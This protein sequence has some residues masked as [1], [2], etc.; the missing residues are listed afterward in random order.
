MQLNK[1]MELKSM[2]ETLK[3]QLNEKLIKAELLSKECF[4]TNQECD[5]QL[6]S[7]IVT[8]EYIKHVKRRIK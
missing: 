6:Q 7:G 4:E 3:S 5:D 8:K 1:Q 2:Q